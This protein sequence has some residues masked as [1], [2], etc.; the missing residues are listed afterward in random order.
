MR[1]AV[2]VFRNQFNEFRKDK[3]LLLFFFLW[4]VMVLALPAISEMG[5]GEPDNWDYPSQIALGAGVMVAGGYMIGFLSPII[6]K[7][8]KEGHLSRVK[9]ISY[10]LGV[11]GF[12]VVLCMGVALFIAWVGELRGHALANYMLIMLLAITCSILIA[13]IIGILSKTSKITLRISVPI[14]VAIGMLLKVRNGVP[15]LQIIEPIRPFINW[16]YTERINNMLIEVH[17]GNFMGDIYVVLGNIAF[18]TIVFT[19]LCKM[20][21]VKS[22]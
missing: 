17:T 18:L 15:A 6:A 22:M 13:A 16:F 1:D 10:L 12:F 11:G 8:R 4:L 3:V 20:K 2:A 19:A 9:L 21:R 7:H 14:G 5:F